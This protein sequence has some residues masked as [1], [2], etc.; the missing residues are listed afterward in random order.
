MTAINAESMYNK[1]MAVGLENGEF[2][3]LFIREAK[4][5][6]EEKKCFTRK[7]LSGRPESG[8][9]SGYQYKQLDHWNY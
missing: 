1:H 4:N 3:I 5:V 9:D 8:S 2:Y 7:G 6:A